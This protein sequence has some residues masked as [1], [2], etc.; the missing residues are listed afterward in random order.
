MYSFIVSPEQE[1]L[2]PPYDLNTDT[3]DNFFFS[4]RFYRAFA[5]TRKKKF[6]KEDIVLDESR[7]I[8]TLYDNVSYKD[9][10]LFLN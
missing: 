6:M 2:T 9:I 1:W 5:W 8:I 10:V 4:I 7:W 3:V